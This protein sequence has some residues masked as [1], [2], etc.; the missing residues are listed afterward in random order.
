M[1]MSQHTALI[2]AEHGLRIFPCRADK[3]P[4]T[5][6][7]FKDASTDPAQIRAWWRRWP[8]ADP[9]LAVAATVVVVDI[10]VKGDRNGYRDFERLAGRDP[11]GIDAPMASTPSGGMQIFYAAAKPYRNRVAIAGTGLDTRS[12]GGY[13]VLPAPGNGREWLRPY[14]GVTPPLAPPWL[15]VALKQEDIRSSAATFDPDLP[16]LEYDE[17][18]ARAALVRACVRIA[19]APCGTQDHTRNAECFFIGILVGRGALDEAEAIAALTR[20][21][22]AMP[23]HRDPWRDLEERVAKSFAA[24]V[25]KAA[26]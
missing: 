3:T 21:A 15:D 24:G 6:H 2:Y 23:A 12:E 25:R 10:D 26:S 22:K 17:E 14:L 4:L 13:V 5:I 7:G 9:A 18:F 16:P 1:S 19:Y 20:A 8:F 11:R